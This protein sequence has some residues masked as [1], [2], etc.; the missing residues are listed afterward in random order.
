MRAPAEIEGGGAA[1]REPK[2]HDAAS[3]DV[4]R[5][6]GVGQQPIE[7]GGQVGRALGQQIERRGDESPDV[8]P[9]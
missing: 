5:E 6:G 9:G 4:R 1:E 2:R 3:I 7:R 8:L